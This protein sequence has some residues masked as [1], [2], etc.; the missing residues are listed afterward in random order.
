M[1]QKSRFIG[2]CFFAENAEAASE[3]LAQIRKREWDATHH[4]HAC[5]I[6][7]D[8]SYVRSSDDGEPSGT[9][10]APIL[11][12]LS[13]LELTNTL[14][15]VTRYFGGIL[16]G[17]GG[18][19]RAYTG[20]AAAAAEAAGVVLMRPASGYRAMFSYSQWA[21]SEASLRRV[22]DVSDVAYAEVVTATFW[23]FDGAADQVVEQI[24]DRTDGRVTPELVAHEMRPY[25]EC[26][27]V[28]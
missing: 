27:F 21:A 16:L 13:R 5:R 7:T 14:C 28:P 20:A 9:A 24:Y 19:V 18:L 8:G 17:A 23:L 4:C 25:Q 11:G 10:G 6:G 2:R 22:A 12:V 1:I 26:N 15:V 3:I